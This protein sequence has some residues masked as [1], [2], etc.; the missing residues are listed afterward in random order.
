MVLPEPTLALVQ[1]AIFFKI[2]D[3]AGVNHAFKDLAKTT[4]QCNGSVTE[5]FSVVLLWFGDWDHRCCP[6]LM[7]EITRDPDDVQDLFDDL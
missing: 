3:K 2:P 5:W 7:R 1:Y 4:G 6:L